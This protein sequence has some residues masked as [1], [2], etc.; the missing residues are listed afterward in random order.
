MDKCESCGWDEIEFGRIGHYVWS[1]VT[2]AWHGDRYIAVL[3]D[4]ET[5]AGELEYRRG[6]YEAALAHEVELGG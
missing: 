1:T 3:V 2:K 6:R 5:Y 4:G